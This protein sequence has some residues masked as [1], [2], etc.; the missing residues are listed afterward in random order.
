ML[1]IFS[2]DIGLVTL[3]VDES[4]ARQVMEYADLPLCERDTMLQSEFEGYLVAQGKMM[5]GWAE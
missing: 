1:K 4:T 5:D 2:D 3:H